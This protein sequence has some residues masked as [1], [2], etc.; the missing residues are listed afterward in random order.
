MAES[1]ET[2]CDVM[3]AFVTRRRVPTGST[4]F[5]MSRMRLEMMLLH[6]E[7]LLDF[8]GD[9]QAAG[10]AHVTVRNCDVSR[11]ERGASTAPTSVQPRLKAECQVDLV[12]LRGLG[13]I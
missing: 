13:T 7:D 9:L 11:I 2:F 3:S 4:G 12:Y 1:A 8:L 5:V 10:R 6:E